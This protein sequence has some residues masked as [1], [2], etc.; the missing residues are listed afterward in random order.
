MP[1]SKNFYIVTDMDCNPAMN[2]AGQ[3]MEFTTE[4][5]VLKV[6]KERL[7][8]SPDDEV[9]VWKLSLVVSRPDVEPVVTK[10]K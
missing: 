6:A 4:K 5:A 8:G 2:D 10:Y 9:W 1:R 3:N 7:K